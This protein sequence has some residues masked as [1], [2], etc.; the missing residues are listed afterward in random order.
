MHFLDEMVNR[1]FTQWGLHQQVA[2]AAIIV[3]AIFIVACTVLF[4]RH[5]ADRR[6]D[7]R[8]PLTNP[9]EISWEDMAGLPQHS[10]GRCLDF[11]AGGLRMEL[12]DRM[13]VPARIKFRVLNSDLAGIALVRYCRRSGPKYVAGAEFVSLSQ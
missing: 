9:V 6:G 11:S 2:A 5:I 4:I 10:Q 12:P 8:E 3:L 7:S 1:P 13:D